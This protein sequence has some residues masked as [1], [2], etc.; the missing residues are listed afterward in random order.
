MIYSEREEKSIIKD[1]TLSSKV[2]KNKCCIGVLIALGIVVLITAIVLIVIFCTGNKDPDQPTDKVTKDKD[3]DINNDDNDEDKDKDKEKDKEEDETKPD[4]I[5]EEKPLEKEFEILTEI[6]LRKVNVVQNS[7][8]ENKIEGNVF[9]TNITRRTNYHIYILS[10]EKADNKTLK[11]YNSTF[12]GAIA[13]SSECYDSEGED[14]EPHRL[15]DLSP[16]AQTQRRNV[17]RLNDAEELKNIPIALCLF[18]ITDN[19]FILSMECPEAFPDVKKNEIILDLY[20]YKPPAIRRADKEKDG[21][22]ITINEEKSDGKRFIREK[23][24]GTCNVENNIG[25][26]CTTDMNTTTDLNGKVI[27]YDEL[28]ITNITTDENNSYLKKK[29]SNLI[30]LTDEDIDLDPVKYKENLD[31]LLSLIKPYMKEDIHFTMKDF[32]ELYSVVQAKK[33]NEEVYIEEIK[34]TYRNLLSTATQYIYG[35]TLFYYEDIG[36]IEVSLNL[37]ADSGLKDISQRTYSELLFDKETHS[38]SELIEYTDLGKVLDELIELSKAGNHLATELYEK[39]KDKFEDIKNDI[40]LKINSLNELIEYY[41][42][43]EIFDATL[44]LDSIRKLPIHI[45]D[46]SKKMENK[47]NSIYEEIVTGTTKYY[48]DK[49]KNY[50]YEFNKYSQILVQKIFNNLKDLTTILSS[51]KNELTEI[52]TYYLN[53]SSDSYEDKILDIEKI[54]NTY[55]ID[56]YN[57][58]YD[59]IKK[60]F[61]EFEQNYIETLKSPKKLIN[62]FISKLENKSY[63]IDYASDED[64]KNMISYLYNSNQITNDIIDR[65]KNYINKEIGLNDNGYFISDNEIQK[66]KNSFTPFLT[67]A[68]EEAKKLDNDEYIDKVFDKIMINFED[69]ITDIIMDMERKKEEQFPLRENALQNDLF[70]DDSRKQIEDQSNEIKTKIRSIINEENDYYIGE[71]KGNITDFI[72]KD[73]IDLNNIISELTVLLSEEKLNNLA[74]NF[75]SILSKIL[76]KISK[77]ILSNENLA[78]KYFDEYIKVLNDNNYLSNLVNQKYQISS[79]LG[80]KKFIRIDYLTIYSKE[81]TNAYI[82]KY[83]AY[84]ANFEYSKK[85]ILNNLRL[86]IM[87][88]YKEVISKIKKELQSIRNLKITEKYSDIPEFEFYNNNLRTIDKLFSR[89]DKYLSDDIFN[90]KYLKMINDFNNLNIS[91]INSIDANINNRHNTINKLKLYGDNSNDF[92]FSFRRKVCYGCTNCCW[93]TYFDQRICIPLSNTNIHLQLKKTDAIISNTDLIE[94][95]NEFNTFY[96]Q[97]NNKIINYNSRWLNLENTFKII[98]QETLDKKF[99]LNYLQPLENFVNAIIAEKLEDKLI[100]ASY[101]FYKNL[102]DEK[103]PDIFEEALNN[104][105]STLHYLLNEIQSNFDLF[106]NS[107]FEYKIMTSIYSSIFVQNSTRDFFNIIITFEKIEFNSTISYYYSYI[108]KIIDEAHQY[109]MS[110][111]PTNEKGFNDII[112]LRIKEV[113][114]IFSTILLKI[115]NSKNIAL[116]FVKQQSLLNVPETNFFKVNNIMTDHIYNLKSLFD[117]KVSELSKLNKYDIDELALVSRFFLEIQQNWKRTLRFY[118]QADHEVFVTL[119]LDKFEEIVFQNWIFDQN[120]FI[121]KLSIILLDS[122]KEI[123]NDF[124]LKKDNYI[125]QL[126]NEIDKQFTDESPEIKVINFFSSE[127]KDLTSEQ[128]RNI[129]NYIQSIVNVIK[130]KIISESNR[131]ETTSTSYNSNYTKIKETLQKYKTKISIDLDST[132]EIIING[133]YNNINKNF[134]TDCIISN[135]DEYVDVAQK[136]T[137]KNDYKEYKLYNSSYK[138]GEI[139]QNLTE[140]IVSDYK[141]NIKGIMDQKHTEILNK[142]KTNININNIINSVNNQID[143]TYNNYLLKSLNKSASNDPTNGAYYPYDFTSKITDDIDNA[144]SESFKNIK[145]ELEKTKGSNYDININCYLDFSLSGLNIIKDICTDFKDFL[146]SEKEDQKKKLN[147]FIKGVIKS[148]YNDLL[149]NIIPTFGTEFFDK[150]IKYNE[151]FRINSLYNNLKFSLVQSLLYFKYL[152]K[153]STDILPRELKIR[154]YNLNN[155]D[156]IVKSRNREILKLLERKITEFINQSKIDIMN[157]YLKRLGEDVHIKLNFDQNVLDNINDN[158]LEMHPDLGK[159]Y[160]EMAE[161]FFKEK[162]MKAY[163]DYM[164]KKTDEMA[165]V[166][167]E[168]REILMAEIDDLF[169]FDTNQIL[170]EINQKLNDTNDSISEYKEYMESFVLS[171]DIQEYLNDFA[172]NKI[173]PILSE[174]QIEINKLTKDKIILNIDKNSENITKLNSSQFIIESKNTTEYF[175]N[176]YFSNINSSIETYGVDDYEKNLDYEINNKKLSLRRRLSGEETEEDIEKNVKEKVND[177]ELEETFDKILNLSTNTKNFYDGLEAINNM[178]KKITNCIKKLNLASKKSEELITLND[179]DEEVDK[180]LKEKVSNLTNISQEYYNAINE[181]YYTLKNNI[182]QSL[183]YMHN[184]LNK[185]ADITFKTFNQKYQNIYE[186]TNKINTRY[187]NES[188]KFN[189]I[190]YYRRTEHSRRDGIAKILDFIEYSEFNFDLYFEGDKLKKPIVKCNIVDKSRPKRMSFNISSRFGTCGETVNEINVNFNDANYTMNIDYS[191]EASSNINISTFTNFDKYIYS[192]KVYQIPES[193]QTESVE[194]GG[195]E[196]D[197]DETVCNKRRKHE[198]K[199]EFDTVVEAVHYNETTTIES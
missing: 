56:G 79:K 110:E 135:L 5:E 57:K 191:H 131:L 58:I 161:S 113:N 150:I 49:L 75:E 50:V 31:K 198:L 139:I 85:Y 166:V 142:I 17:R 66:N 151:N 107:I 122:S 115:S 23:N 119:N 68:K 46:E 199:N 101:D 53:T 193:N 174:F 84:K 3:N 55:Y 157:E 118:E 27:S 197:F 76:N 18:T 74:K 25:T 106:S 158:L 153:T 60:M 39:I 134:Y 160:L 77:E 136:E 123:R 124:L 86:D 137:S 59:P 129:I 112:N 33:K 155:L 120:D 117:S 94:F 7:F 43:S 20:F 89:L 146:G 126:E 36:G 192:T 19:N 72:N 143:S 8:E 194:T 37:K 145:T 154:I 22:D 98:K 16:K 51:E 24:E 35:S 14:C 71:I 40:K 178:D 121:K 29:T 128:K 140:E 93:Y 97:L 183:I 184:L 82:S 9:I 187:S 34:P 173:I 167:N 141:T 83:N 138:V 190:E 177:R 10:E 38:L 73:S 54:L 13:I 181:S 70:D 48:V 92:C 176:N 148:N 12:K 44:S 162:L 104:F 172:A 30:D 188:K 69:N 88:E 147:T 15:V 185:C 169:S 159:N 102:I 100:K 6:G 61:T 87:N 95:K 182:N 105:N 52:T 189:P 149:N 111:I 26:K 99:T 96:Q 80:S 45:I 156:S 41:E 1:E 67:A 28:A 180:L 78:N 171:N 42:L 11:Y 170:E 114:D 163:S 63:T 179:Y 81:K 152:Y 175:K 133:L 125:N 65:I 132:L 4:I 195:I 116:S 62:H 168:Q 144:I 90:N 108:K 21:I 130:E 32:E 186:K 2:K 109:I 47:L 64:F 164:N 196:V 127:I 165:K 103:I 91:K